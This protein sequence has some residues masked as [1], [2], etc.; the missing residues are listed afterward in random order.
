MNESGNREPKAEAKA[1]VFIS[2][3]RA[4]MNFADRL[5]AA[6]KARGFEPFIDR[7]EI[8]SFEDWWKRIQALI[9]KADTIIFVL[10]PDA[11][12]S[13]V[14]R[15]EVTFA[16]SLNKRFAPIVCRAVDAAHVPSELSRLNFISFE[17]EAR[18]E[19][20]AEKLVRA[21]TTDIEWIRKH[22]ELGELARHWSEVGRPSGLLLRS[23][24]LDD[25]EQ[26]FVRQ[27]QGAPPPTEATR[28]FVIESRKAEMLA[29]ARRRRIAALVGVLVLLLITAG[30]GWWKQDWLKEQYHWRVVMR[31]TVLTAEEER[32]LASK[33]E[34]SECAHGCPT[35]VVVPA[36]LFTMGS[37]DG[38]NNERPPHTVTFAKP[39][40]VGKYD[41]TFAE[42]DA[43]AAADACARASDTG[44]GRENRPVINVSWD[45]AK[46]YVA[47]LS[48]MTGKEYR[49]LSEAE[50][51]YA[52]RAGT[53]TKYY[54]GNDV[55]Q[56]NANCDNCGSQWDDKQTA[57]VGSFKPNPFGLYDMAGNVF[58]WVEDVHHSSYAGAPSDGSAW[59]EGRGDRE[60]RGGSWNNHAD[61]YLRSTSRVYFTPGDRL[62]TI[63]FRVARTLT[64]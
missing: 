30:I 22:T 58:Q 10:S 38:E 32:S 24:A 7:T 11:I 26:W 2:Y 33:G 36:G 44:W 49:L 4:D 42:W 31:P 55:G 13:D 45:E 1:K 15:K 21:L 63:G 8:Y 52:A 41:V 43:C 23:P 9:G 20:S 27:P 6:L 47:W 62:F 54:W 28:A 50:W 40:A 53:T 12:S 18:F 17:D 51:E 16:A 35:M 59:I 37:Q 48:R 29:R 57:P 39:F 60:V 14:C 25:A 61:F 64:P 3:S 5:D 19:E 46:R 56:G 34:F